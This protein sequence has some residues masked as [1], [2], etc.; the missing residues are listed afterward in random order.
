MTRRTISNIASFATLGVLVTAAGCGSPEH[1]GDQ[2]AA[3]TAT[4]HADPTFTRLGA[5]QNGGGSVEISAYDARTRRL[6]VVNSTASPP[7]VEI[8]D[9]TSP[10]APVLRGVIL[11]P[12][13]GVPNS[14]AVHDGLVAVAWEAI[15]R[16]QPGS[17]VFYDAATATAL[18]AVTVGA[19]PDMLTFTK[20]GDRVL[21]ANEGEPAPDYTSDPEGSVSVIDVEERDGAYAFTAST[22][23]FLPSTP[24]V[25]ASSIRVF[26]GGAFGA[27]SVPLSTPAQDYEPEYITV[28]DDGRTA[29]VTLQENNAIA[30]LDV[31]DRRFTKI[32]GL[33]FKDHALPGNGLDAS[34]RDGP[35]GTAGPGNIQTWPV[36]GIYMP[37]AIGHF[38]HR[39]RDFLVTANEGDA[40]EW[41]SFVEEA[42]VASLVP[43]KDANGNYVAT[44]GKLRPDHPAL[45]SGAASDVARLGRLSVTTKGVPLDANGSL[46]DLFAFG[47]RSFSI[48]DR[49]GDLVF[50]SGDE[51]EQQIHR[52]LPGFENSDQTPNPA[53]DSRSDNK[54]PEPEG[55]AVAKIR[56][57]TYA[58]IG[59]ERVGGVLVY[60]LEDPRRPRFVTYLNHRTF[61]PP[62]PGGDLGPEGLMVIRKKDSPTRRP[63]LVVSNE[64]SGT[65]TFFEIG[66]G[67]SDDPDDDD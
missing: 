18:G 10:A 39:G 36:K 5:F 61:S 34:D 46:V 4:L 11:N 15:D 58:F 53:P 17:V 6:F 52:L 29:W 42:R 26:G 9:I 57:T 45:L 49:N 67:G 20:K 28:S 2:A 38:E 62:S 44:A 22:V 12:S 21:V 48:R 41:G 56:G 50:D 31:R 24:R 51:I 40:R 13:A 37:D 16:Q 14:V 19:V 23:P 63:I 25:N 60:A 65:A 54:G 27:M 64:I 30:I 33:G 1:G 8:V 35:G 43:P 55:L 66:G 47:G 59:L 7:K 32:V 3:A